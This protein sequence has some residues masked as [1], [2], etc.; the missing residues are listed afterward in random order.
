LAGRPPAQA[1]RRQAGPRHPRTGP[2]HS[3]AR[4]SRVRGP[5]CAARRHRPDHWLTAAADPDGHI[6]TPQF[7]T[8]PSLPRW[9]SPL[10]L[11]TRSGSQQRHNRRRNLA[12]T[13]SLGLQPQHVSNLAHG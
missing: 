13:Q 8:G 9:R 6:A 12:I 1:L 2:R 7:G 10:R 3:T 5:G 4:L 11:S